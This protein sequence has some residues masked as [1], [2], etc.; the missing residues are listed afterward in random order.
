MTP[1]TNWKTRNLRRLVKSLIWATFVAFLGWLLGLQP[2]WQL[3]VLVLAAMVID[4]ILDAWLPTDSDNK[5]HAQALIAAE[6]AGYQRG[7]NESKLR[8]YGTGKPA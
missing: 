1:P 2:T 4:N 6:E 3:L 8:S 5:E 7:I